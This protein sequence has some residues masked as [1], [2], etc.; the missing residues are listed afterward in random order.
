MLKGAA[1]FE[2]LGSVAPTACALQAPGRASRDRVV[3]HK[4]GYCADY[5]DQHAVEVESCNPWHAEDM[6]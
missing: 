2:L 5:R 3:E 4:N 1:D 6:K